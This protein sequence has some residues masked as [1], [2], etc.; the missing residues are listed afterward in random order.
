MAVSETNT[1]AASSTSTLGD[2][3]T[4]EPAVRESASPTRGASELRENQPADADAIST[5]PAGVEEKAFKLRTLASTYAEGE[6]LLY[7]LLLERAVGDHENR[8]IALTGRYGTGK[9]S[10]LDQ[11]VANHPDD[12]VRI[13]INTLGPDP[14][15]DLTNRIQKELVKQLVYLPK[16]GE[17]RTS[18]FA[19]PPLPRRWQNAALILFVALLVT[20]SL[21]LFGVRPTL[22]PDDSSVFANPWWGVAVMFLLSAIA[23]ALARWIIGDRAIVEVRAAGAAVA[24]GKKSD[25]YFDE[26]LDEIV[27]FFEVKN[28]KYV[29]FEDL[30]RFEDPQIFDSLR[31]LNTLINARP[32]SQRLRDRVKLRGQWV[33]SRLQG[34]GLTY[35]E[36]TDKE[37]T[38]S[39]SIRFIYAIKDSLFEKLGTTVTRTPANKGQAD[40]EAESA[41]D[42]DPNPVNGNTEDLARA[43]VERA[44][45]TKFFEIVIPVVPFIT[46]INARDHLLAALEERGLPKNTVSR[47]L[48]DLLGTHTTDMRLLLNI[49]N[50]FIVFAYRLLWTPDRAPGMTADHLFALV[51]YKNFHLTDFERIPQQTSTLDALVTKHSVSVD[52]MV[53]DL[54]MRRQNLDVDNDLSRQQASR[55]KHWGD[56][57]HAY[58][59]AD[60]RWTYATEAVVHQTIYSAEAF[61]GVSMWRDAAREGSTINVHGQVALTKEQLEAMFPGSTDPQTWR[62]VRT[63][64]LE[65]ERLQIDRRIEKIRAADFKDLIA[66]TSGE[67]TSQDFDQTIDEVLQSDLARQL[68]RRGYITKLFAV[69]AAKFYHGFSGAD[70][71]DYYNRH[72]IPG[73]MDLNHVFTTEHAVEHLLD[74]VPEF[75][76][77]T[78]SVLHVDIVS[79]LVREHVCGAQ[80]SE[81]VSGAAEVAAYIAS[82][83]S[84]DAKKFLY[85]FFLSES[86]PRSDFVRLLARTPWA[87]LF[88]YLSI[89]DEVTTRSADADA[90]AQ[91]VLSLATRQWLL[92]HALLDAQQPQHYVL[93]DKTRAFLTDSYTSIEAFTQD[94]GDATDVVFSFAQDAEIVASDLSALSGPMRARFVGAQMYELTLSN[95]RLALGTDDAPTLDNVEA[96]PAVRSYVHAHIGEYLNVMAREAAGVNVVERSDLLEVLLKEH[97]TDW[98][99]E[100]FTRLL[101]RVS[102][103]AAVPDITSVDAKTW[104]WLL[105]VRAVIPTPANVAAY[106]AKYGVDEAMAAFLVDGE[107]TVVWATPDDPQDVLPADK[108]TDLAISILNS[109]LS[110]SAMVKLVSTLKPATPL[111]VDQVEAREDDLYSRL[112]TADLIANTAPTFAHFLTAGWAAV[113]EAVSTHSEVADLISPTLVGKHLIDAL[114]DENLP[115]SVGES[116]VTGMVE[117]ALTDEAVRAVGRYAFTNRLPVPSDQLARLAASHDSA[118]HALY[119]FDLNNSLS[120][121][122][123]VSLLISVGEPFND[124]GTPDAEFEMPDGK[125]ARKLMT[126][127]KD[128]GRVQL[129]P[130]SRP[131]VVQVLPLSEEE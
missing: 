114:A 109:D 124:L 102:R 64:E 27:T 127:L 40:D 119:Q 17:I 62:E 111:P 100:E 99:A 30:D 53:N 105:A 44:N 4:H 74:Q 72:V 98:T 73:T 107:S 67:T 95:L 71:A 110:T 116:F 5:V 38:T 94:Q 76:A 19:R 28:P 60:S 36:F 108:N 81:R 93:N 20:G 39:E 85:R 69:Y 117:Y 33:R 1:S 92:S 61:R 15:E 75:F 82:N 77:S 52:K 91:Q 86:A 59:V 45:R 113:S 21:W 123:L 22:W 90:A 101:K 9:S 118:D 55:A 88:D 8:N 6:H 106:C 131:K 96:L 46:H 125:W 97:L 24:L 70:V 14:S 47:G 43:E 32:R 115:K 104:K 78:P 112:L 18:R 11:F 16:R 2:E 56:R 66:L 3:R 48:L 130:P 68:V 12:T 41:S 29:V 129:S 83:P 63:E 26:Y 122:E 79:H 49:C 120:P 54:L 51:A 103:E 121:D 35:K 7:V 80:M 87:G 25:S 31:E 37:P 58:L 23:A 50:E 57:L 84:A 10:V 42:G 13:S 126:R 34:E 65:A 128:A 89:S